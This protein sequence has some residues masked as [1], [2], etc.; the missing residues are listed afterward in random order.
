M[1]NDSLQRYID[2]ESAKDGKAIGYYRELES[3]REQ[4][5]GDLIDM[6]RG[7]LSKKPEKY[8]QCLAQQK[9]QGK[10]EDIEIEAFLQ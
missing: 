3:K 5:T 9:E 10:Y 1:S 7:I 6:I 4:W 8:R 2:S